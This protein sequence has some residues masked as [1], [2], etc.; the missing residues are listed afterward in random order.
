MIDLLTWERDA[1]QSISQFTDIGGLDLRNKRILKLIH[2]VRSLKERHDDSLLIEAQRLKEREILIKQNEKLRT[3][4]ADKIY[5]KNP[6]LEM[7]TKICE[8]GNPKNER[9]DLCEKL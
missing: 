8:H 7:I 4:L 2:E 3:F 6:F 5:A 9:C 1:L